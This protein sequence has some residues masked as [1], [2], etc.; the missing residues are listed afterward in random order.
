MAQRMTRS[1]N[2][3]IQTAK[4]ISKGLTNH[5]LKSATKIKTKSPR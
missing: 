4:K 3:K 5:Y 1:V 2:Q